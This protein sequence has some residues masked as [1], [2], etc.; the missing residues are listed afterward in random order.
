MLAEN[1]FLNYPKERESEL[2]FD[3]IKI[4]A[5]FNNIIDNANK[6]S[7]GSD[8]EILVTS[9]PDIIFD[10]K[11]WHAIKIIVKDSGIGIPAEE[12]E[13]IFEPFTLGSRT[14]DGSGG[15]GLGLAIAREV[16]TAH[17]G[18]I[19]AY[20]NVDKG[21]SMEIILPVKH[22][23]AKFL[24][25]ARNAN[26]SNRDMDL[27]KIDLGKIIADTKKIDEKY[28]GKTPKI[29]M[30]DDDPAI[31]SAG[32]MIIK[33]L[34]Y[35]FM[36]ISTGD[37]AVEYINGDKFDSSLILL[38]MMLGDTDGLEVMKD[39]KARIDETK[40]PVIIQSGL[41]PKEKSVIATL[42]LGAKEFMAKP[43]KR[44]DIDFVIRKYLGLE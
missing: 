43:Y 16:I 22:P 26:N 3:E 1:I 35:E 42:E 40:V 24:S 30:I 20:N 9:A 10:G 25:D 33:S 41:S 27:E 17:Q 32:G 12:L 38:D 2:E 6:Y 21:V 36:G 7:E 18:Y 39:V 4:R 44:A 31:L 23:R 34:G 37:E 15:R 8:I 29:L 5:M 11:N 28:Q 19:S 14:S 13:K